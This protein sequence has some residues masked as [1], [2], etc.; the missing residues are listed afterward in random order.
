MP[1]QDIGRADSPP[2]NDA[3]Q[4]CHLVGF[5]DQL[6]LRHGAS[7]DFELANGRH[8]TLMQESIV[9]RSTLVVVSD[10]REITTRQGKKLTLIGTVSAVKPE[11]LRELHPP[12]AGLEE[13]VE[14][15]YDRLHRRVLAALVLR[16]RSLPISGTPLDQPDP[17]EAAQ[18]LAREFVRNPHPASVPRWDR[19]LKPW[20][21]CVIQLRDRKP[22]LGLPDFDDEQIMRGLAQA[23]HGA[24]SFKEAADRPLLPAFLAMLTPE[25]QAAVEAVTRTQ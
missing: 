13:R 9:R 16:Y 25:Q 23:W 1:T 22:E 14:H 2:Y 24:A 5:V 12:P 7:E 21:Q 3:I 20:L 10:I 18:V 11:W 6:A 17:A 19:E 15:I 4:K 8:A